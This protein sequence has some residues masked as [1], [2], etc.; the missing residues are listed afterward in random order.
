MARAA[1]R[2]R[3]TP[4]SVAAAELGELADRFSRLL[5]EVEQNLLKAAAAF[6]GELD[7]RPGFDALDYLLEKLGRVEQD[8]GALGR[9]VEEVTGRPRVHLRLVEPAGGGALEAAARRLT[10]WCEARIPEPAR[11]EVELEVKRRGRTLTIVER[12][13]PGPDGRG[14]WTRR[15]CAQFRLDASGTWSLWWS[16]RYGRWR[17]YDADDAGTGF[18]DL[19]GAVELDRAGVF[20]G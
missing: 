8:A 9:A 4:G 11:L 19:L 1:Q 10:Q 5:G 18:E 17:P 13:W 12:R 7:A 14:T 3:V 20:W 6:D 16:D 15:G 2:R